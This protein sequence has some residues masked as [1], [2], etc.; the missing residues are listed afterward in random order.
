MIDLI[1]LLHI[2]TAFF[3]APF[4]ASSLPGML[5]LAIS[6][7]AKSIFSAC[8]PYYYI[9]ALFPFAVHMLHR[10]HPDIYSGTSVR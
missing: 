2:L 9:A 4:T 7:N 8:E 10:C 1:Y 3:N 5:N 6:G